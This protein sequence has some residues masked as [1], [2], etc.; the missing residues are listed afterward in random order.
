[1]RYQTCVKKQN[2]TV[3]WAWIATVLLA[4]IGCGGAP[5]GASG[6]ALLAPAATPTPTEVPLLQIPASPP[7]VSPIKA[8]AQPE[9]F[10]TGYSLV[11]S[12]GPEV[13]GRLQKGENAKGLISI[14]WAGPTCGWSL[15]GGLF[16]IHF[17]EQT[18]TSSFEWLYPPSMIE[19][20]PGVVPCDPAAGLGNTL[21]TATVSTPGGTVVCHYEGTGSGTGEACGAE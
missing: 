9:S 12:P 16:L 13:M 20:T 5:S 3:L 19:R 17:V 4:G 7:H 11:I 8:N 10:R 18:V 14:K 1:V 2:R 6:N 21:I 15:G